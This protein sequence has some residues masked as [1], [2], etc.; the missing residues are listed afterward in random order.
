M[1][2]NK[3]ESVLSAFLVGGIVGAALGVLLTPH[4]GKDTRKRLN[5]WIDDALDETK[6]TL[7]TIQ[8]EIK[9]HKDHLVNKA[10]HLLKK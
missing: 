6:D 5:R 10:Q 8:D 3:T 9:Y 4:S 2:D 1:A 7:E